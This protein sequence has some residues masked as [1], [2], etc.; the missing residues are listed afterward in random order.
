MK[1]RGTVTKHAYPIGFGP[2]VHATF[3][4]VLMTGYGI[5]EMIYVG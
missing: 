2:G 4:R 3:H 1:I 5:L